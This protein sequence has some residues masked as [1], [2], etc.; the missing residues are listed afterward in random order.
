MILLFVA[1]ACDNKDTDG[2]DSTDECN[3]ASTPKHH[4]QMSIRAHS[5]S[6]I[7]KRG[8]LLDLISE[9]SRNN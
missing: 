1:L 8:S 7:R 6:P 3:M 4:M 2:F 9:T 5:P